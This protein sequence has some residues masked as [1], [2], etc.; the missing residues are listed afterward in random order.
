MSVIKACSFDHN[1][2]NTLAEMNTTLILGT[3]TANPTHLHNENTLLLNHTR[4]RTKILISDRIVSIFVIPLYARMPHGCEN[5][6]DNKSDDENT[7]DVL[8]KWEPIVVI[9]AWCFTQDV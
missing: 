9:V 7:A 3:G 8:V 6:D 4:T 1:G 5:M 2:S